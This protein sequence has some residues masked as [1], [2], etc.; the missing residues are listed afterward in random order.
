[1]GDG[2][3]FPRLQVGYVWPSLQFAPCAAAP[4]HASN[5]CYSEVR[6]GNGQVRGRPEADPKGSE[7]EGAVP[8]RAQ[9]SASS[10]KAPR[11][12]HSCPPWSL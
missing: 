12:P 10:K 4:S 7:K 2:R 1:M 3:S 6:P 5:P 11:W 8:L 9:E